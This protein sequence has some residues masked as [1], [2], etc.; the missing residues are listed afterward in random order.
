MRPS[1]AVILGRVSAQKYS[2]KCSIAGQALPRYCTER[3]DG[4]HEELRTVL[5]RRQSR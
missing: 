3:K 4:D 2:T 5:P 1:I